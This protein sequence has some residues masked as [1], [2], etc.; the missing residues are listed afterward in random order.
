MAFYDEVEDI[1]I[2]ELNKT[3]IDS[4]IISGFDNNDIITISTP[5]S[6]ND[7]WTINTTTAISEWDP[8]SEYLAEQLRNTLCQ[9]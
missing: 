9:K 8:L 5:V 7:N 6:P 2:D 4:K 3:L 1:N